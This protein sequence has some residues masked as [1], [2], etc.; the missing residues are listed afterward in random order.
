M[1]Q[2]SYK[3]PH[4]LIER[5][6][7]ITHCGYAG[8]DETELS[9][10][11]PSISVEAQFKYIF[12]EVLK[13]DP[14]QYNVVIVKDAGTT[15][16]VLR[17]E[18]HLLFTKF[19]VKACAFINAQVGIIFAL[20]IRGSSGLIIDIGYESTLIVPIIDLKTQMDLFATLPMAG[21]TIEQFIINHLMRHGIEKEIIENYKDQLFPYLMKDYYYFDSESEHDFEREEI[22]S[23]KKNL[24]KFLVLHDNE[25]KLIK[26][27]LPNPIL[28]TNIF[29]E[30]C[31][32]N[33]IAFTKAFS[34]CVI[35][36][37]DKFGMDYLRCFLEIYEDYWWVGRIIITGGA[38]NILGLRSLLI[39]ELL[40]KTELKIDT[41][42][43]RKP[44]SPSVGIDLRGNSFLIRNTSPEHSKFAWIGGS[45]T[46][47]LKGFKKAFVS[48]EI[49]QNNS[50]MFFQ[51]DDNMK[52]SLKD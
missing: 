48:K 23:R 47:S 40:S 39:R 8:K 18:A 21:R 20:G 33:N 2:N 28:P 34:D 35:K 38:S 25:G 16:Q 9:F 4:I 36:I 10:R 42:C 1:A 44:S 14:T 43:K 11:T 15:Q 12:E 17:D 3:T 26:I 30:K 19:H 37:L 41:K 22:E 13:I 5:G 29:N 49:Y 50:D 31:N 51:L 46:A 45:L 32:S 7:Y 24:T 27:S 6:S 52:I